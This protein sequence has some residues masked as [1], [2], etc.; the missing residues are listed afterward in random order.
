MK[1]GG[2]ECVFAHNSCFFGISGEHTLSRISLTVPAPTMPH[3]RP[4]CQNG[5]R[6]IVLCQ[7]FSHQ[8]HSG[9]AQESWQP[10]RWS[11]PVSVCLL[12]GRIFTTFTLPIVSCGQRLDD[13]A[14]RT[15]VALRLGL[16]LCIT[17]HRLSVNEPIADW[18]GTML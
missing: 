4:T 16:P 11:S 1:D 3:V 12:S 10:K 7:T 18:P 5:G 8:N 13:E 9:T 14:V 17:I 15:A 6:D 2:L